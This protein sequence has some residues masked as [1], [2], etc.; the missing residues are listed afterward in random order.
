M[1][2]H[3]HNAFIILQIGLLL[4]FIICLVA[5]IIHKIDTTKTSIEEIIETIDRIEKN[6][7][8]T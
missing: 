8:N 2:I 5:E 4:T 3:E 6:Q 7:H 1:T